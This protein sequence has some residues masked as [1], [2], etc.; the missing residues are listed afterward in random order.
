[1]PI[2][3]HRIAKRVAPSIALVVPKP[4]RVSKGRLVKQEELERAVELAARQVEGQGA[5]LIL[6]DSDDDCPAELGPALLERARSARSDILISVVVANR[7]YESWF[8]AAAESIDER[9]LSHNLQA[10]QDPEAI[11]GAKERLRDADTGRR[12]SPTLDQ[13][14]FTRTMNLDQARRAK[15]FDRCYREVERLLRGLSEQEFEA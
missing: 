8:L 5:I 14:S 1:M 9:A 3:L 4:I 10:L 15:S 2:L 11:R 13:P 12:Y 6:L 7:E